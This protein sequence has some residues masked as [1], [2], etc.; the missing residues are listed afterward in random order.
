VAWSIFATVGRRA[1]RLLT[2]DGTTYLLNEDA[3]GDL[4][5][6]GVVR[7][8]EDNDGQFTLDLEHVIDEIEPF[9][10]VLERQA[11]ND[12]GTADQ[13]LARRR[14]LFARFSHRDGQ[15]GR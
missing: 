15:G 10:T 4:V 3:V 2:Y 14:L 7:A 11:R 12:A 5:D 1:T 8:D 13:D 6:R 9:A